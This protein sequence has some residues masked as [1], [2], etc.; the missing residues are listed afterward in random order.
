[1]KFDEYQVAWEGIS[2]CRYA[3][4]E[5]LG[6]RDEVVREVVGLLREAAMKA[7]WI[8][9]SLDWIAAQSL[10]SLQGASGD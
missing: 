3:D 9:T 7:T 4:P 8:N 5:A 2:G 6:R 10:K 1:M